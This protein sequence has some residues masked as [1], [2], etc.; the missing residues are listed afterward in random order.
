MNMLL[1]NCC[2]YAKDWK[3]EFNPDKSLVL[4]LNSKDMTEFSTNVSI[5]SEM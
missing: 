2:K 1:N 5:Y 3:I 4:N